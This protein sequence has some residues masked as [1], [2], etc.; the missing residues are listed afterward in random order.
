VCAHAQ[1]I[2]A[3]FAA[4][5]VL[6]RLGFGFLHPLQPLVPDQL[7][8]SF[9]N[10]DG[11]R[12]D[13]ATAPHFAIRGV[14]HH[15]E[16]PLEL[17][18][19]LNGFDITY[20][21]T[22]TPP[23]PPLS[24]SRH[25]DV[26]PTMKGETW[27]SMVGDWERALEWTVANRQNRWEWVLLWAKDWNDFAWSELRRTRLARIAD[28]AHA[29]GVVV[30]AG[31]AHNHTTAHAARAHIPHTYTHTHTTRRLWNCY[32]AAARVAADRERDERGGR[33]A[34]DRAAPG[35]AAAAGERRRL[36]LRFPVDGERLLRVQPPG[37]HSDAAVD[38]HDHCL[39]HQARQG[40]PS[41]PHAH[42]TRS[43][44]TE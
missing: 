42:R 40:L 22:L 39:H 27:E 24:M 19:F 12:F 35:L 9:A 14:H 1:N 36:R 28:I 25:A 44:H 2:G 38:E 34:P 32:Y 15:T 8:L 6:Q 23:R 10:A 13:L 29:W 7:D 41:T 11:G 37:L 30:G 16:H 20:P 5:E 31:T 26:T 3:H 18:E 4:Y 33:A 21:V 17:M 43:S